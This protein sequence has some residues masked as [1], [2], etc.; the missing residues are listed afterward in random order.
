M[1]N[2]HKSHVTNITQ[3]LTVKFIIAEKSK[4]INT[5]KTDNQDKIIITEKA[6]IINTSKNDNWGD[7]M[8]EAI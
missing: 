7:T 6:K 3:T 5:S 8:Y 2:I 4:D 1:S